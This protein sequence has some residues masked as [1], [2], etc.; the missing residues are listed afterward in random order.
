M[1]NKFPENITFQGEKKEIARQEF[2]M[3]ARILAL[4]SMGDKTVPEMAQALGVTT[5]QANWWLMGCLRYSFV[6]ASEK[7]D[8]DGYYHYSLAGGK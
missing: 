2:A 4:L 3:K 1:E 8:K 6:S 7:A 5:Y